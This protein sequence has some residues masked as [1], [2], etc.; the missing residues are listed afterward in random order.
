MALTNIQSSVT[1][2]AASIQINI[3]NSSAAGEVMY[4]VPTGRK[5]VGNFQSTANGGTILVNGVYIY[6]YTGGS[7]NV[8]AAGSLTTYTLLAGTVVKENAT[9]TSA[10]FGIESAA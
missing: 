10:I 2:T 4:T 8:T 5:F 7:T 6:C 3:P 1:P 9:N